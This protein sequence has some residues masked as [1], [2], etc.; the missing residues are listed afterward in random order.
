LEERIA[1]GQTPKWVN[2][3]RTAVEARAEGNPTKDQMRLMMQA[4]LADLFK[5]A[6][7]FETREAPVFELMQVKSE[8]TGPKLHPHSDGPPCPDDYTM[9]T[10]AVLASDVFPANCDTDQMWERGGCG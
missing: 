7:H 5:L 9:P 3:D 4:L 10:R 1:L 8:K 6:V 2:T